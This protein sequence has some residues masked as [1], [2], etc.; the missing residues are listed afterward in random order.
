MTYQEI[1]LDPFSKSQ[2]AFRYRTIDEGFVLYSLGE[3]GIDDGGHFKPEPG[4]YLGKDHSLAR[5][6]LP[7]EIENSTVDREM[8]DDADSFPTLDFE[9]EN[10]ETSEPEKANP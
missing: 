7:A 3:N 8:S 5:Y 6:L 2:E 1:N 10:L 9:N 4:L